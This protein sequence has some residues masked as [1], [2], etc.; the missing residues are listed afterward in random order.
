MPFTPQD[1][2]ISRL[3]ERA[4]VQFGGSGGLISPLGGAATVLS[5]LVLVIVVLFFYLAQGGWLVSSMTRQLL[6]PRRAQADELLDRL[7]FTVGAYFRSLFVIALFDA[8]LI[9][10]GLAL[11]GVPLALPLAVLIYLGAFFPYIGATVS[12]LLA[13]LVAFADGGL[14]TALAVLAL[15]LGV[16]ALEGNVIEPLVMGKLIRLP[17]FVVLLAIVV[18]ATLLGVLGAF[19]AV[20]VTAA[21]ARAGEYV[22]E[23]REAPAA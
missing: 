4:L 18:G 8:T 15:A 21:M 13:V 19:I 20:P 22:R 11:L 3:A 14:G 10:V 17:A 6:E 1:T 9:G 7:W 16:Q 23:Q 12:G 2:N 5:G